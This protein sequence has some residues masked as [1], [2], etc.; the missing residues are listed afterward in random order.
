MSEN[1]EKMFTIFAEILKQAV[2]LL[3]PDN[4]N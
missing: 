4:T 3:K 2:Y 1:W